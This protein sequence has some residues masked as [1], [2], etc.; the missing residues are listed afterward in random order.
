MLPPAQRLSD[1]LNC[2]ILKATA[3]K[4]SDVLDGL[5]NTILVVECASRPELFQNGRLVADGTTRKTWSG[6]ASVTRPFPTGGVWA[7]H[8]KGFVVDGAQPDG[9]TAIRRGT[10]TS[11]DTVA[12]PC[13]WWV[14]SNAAVF[15][16][17]DSAEELRF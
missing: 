5:S 17:T 11:R 13:C 2:G 6:T 15:S 12:R 9:N 7:S 10:C 16:P 8:N 4:L 3:V 1:P 14:L